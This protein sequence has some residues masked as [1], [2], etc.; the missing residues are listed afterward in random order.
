MGE[1]SPE[2]VDQLP[3][4]EKVL[5]VEEEQ[6]SKTL[7]RGMAILNDTLETLEGD[8]VPG[9]VVFKL[10]DTY[11]FPTDLTNDVAREHDLKIDEEGFEAAMQAQRA[12][13]QQASN[14]GADYNS[15]LG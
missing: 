12:R 7:A 9:D 2:L 13:A 4:I 14:F 8:T 5:R 6:F 10:Y 11:G 3:V 15:K 1:A